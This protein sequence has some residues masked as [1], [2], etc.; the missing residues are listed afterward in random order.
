MAG[1]YSHLH[2]FFNNVNV[3]GMVG[4]LLFCST[5]HSYGCNSSSFYHLGIKNT[6]KVVTPNQGRNWYTLTKAIVSSRLGK[7]LILQVIG[8]DTAA[9]RLVSIDLEQ[10]DFSY[11]EKRP[12]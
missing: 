10:V 9:T 4:P 7:I 8:I 3:I 6:F 2:N 12:P 1:L 11:L 5:M